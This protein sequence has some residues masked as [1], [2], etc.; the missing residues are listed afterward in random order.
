MNGVEAAVG[1][2]T[3]DGATTGTARA[4]LEAVALGCVVAAVMG[5]EA[6]KIE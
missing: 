1:V 2:G 3:L 4:A 6:S 5:W